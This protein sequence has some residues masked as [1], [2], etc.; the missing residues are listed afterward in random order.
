MGEHQKLIWQPLDWGK[1]VSTDTNTPSTGSVATP[2]ATPVYTPNAPKGITVSTLYKT[3]NPAH[4]PEDQNEGTSS[5]TINK[6][7]R[8]KQG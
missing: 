1:P 5:L 4:Q 8:Y 3:P 6:Y 2:K 7:L